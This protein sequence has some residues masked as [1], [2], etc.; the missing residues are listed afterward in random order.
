MKLLDKL[1]GIGNKPGCED[2]EALY[3]QCQREI[4]ANTPEGWDGKVVEM[5][6]GISYCY[7]EHSLEGLLATI[8]ARLQ[9]GWIHAGYD[10]N[11][12]F[13]YKMTC[14]QPWRA[15]WRIPTADG[16]ITTHRFGGAEIAMRHEDNGKTHIGVSSH[17][18]HYKEAISLAQSI[19]D[20]ALSGYL[21][22]E[23][24]SAPS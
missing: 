23:E 20:K 18:S 4:E 3:N 8:P 19:V 12:F 21:K 1:L 10:C 15:N 6:D 9:G 13:G 11:G 14:G 24:A 22:L 17:P 7:A 5:T 2:L 16:D